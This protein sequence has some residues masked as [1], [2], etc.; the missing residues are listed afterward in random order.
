MDISLLANIMIELDI[1]LFNE[2][3]LYDINIIGSLFKAWLRDLPS[4]ILPKAI[5]ARVAAAHPNAAQVPQMLKDEL[6]NLPPWNYYLLFAITCHL[7]LLHD[8]HT[9][10]K[11]SYSNLCICFQPCIGIDSYC[12]QFLVCDW[13][14]CWQGCWTEK[15]YLEQEYRAMAGDPSN[16]EAQPFDDSDSGTIVVEQNTPQS[17]A[18]GNSR[19]GLFSRSR[20]RNPPPPATGSLHPGTEQP[21]RSNTRAGHHRNES[22][23]PELQPMMPLS[24]MAWEKSQ[25]RASVNSPPSGA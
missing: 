3:D 1:D 2:A 23:L 9:T 13:R 16:P 20:E 25:N 8:H 10:N 24:P 22:Q 15:E 14:N 12:F 6:S 17:S 11:M 19:P 4:E 18:S 7:S 21:S 5:Q